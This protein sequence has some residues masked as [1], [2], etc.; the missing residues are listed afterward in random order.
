MIREMYKLQLQLKAHQIVHVELG[1]IRKIGVEGQSIML[2]Y[3]DSDPNNIYIV[4]TGHIYIQS[5]W[6][7][8]YG[9]FNRK[10]AL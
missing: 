6:M 2:W 7:N 10:P 1:S 5:L 3:E 4:G 9:I 8:L